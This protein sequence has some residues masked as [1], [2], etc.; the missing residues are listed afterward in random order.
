MEVGRGGGGLGV[1]EG[2]EG[3]GEKAKSVPQPRLVL[4]FSEVDPKVAPCSCPLLSPAGCSPHSDKPFVGAPRGPLISPGRQP[5]PKRFFSPRKGGGT[6]LASVQPSRYEPPAQ[7]RG[8]G[9]VPY[10]ANPSTVPLLPPPCKTINFLT[11][12]QTLAS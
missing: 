7:A 11:L 4:P 5:E 10:P 1:W 2:A 6:V 12:G 3:L 9:A 8:R